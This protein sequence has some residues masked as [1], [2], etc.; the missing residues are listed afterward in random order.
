MKGEG[1][2][3]IE[4]VDI[5][6]SLT[7]KESA[8]VR[9]IYR[10]SSPWEQEEGEGVL[11]ALGIWNPQAKRGESILTP[12]GLDVRRHLLEGADNAEG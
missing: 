2:P 6:N 3:P 1:L 9:G 5:A 11:Y 7:G 10:W 12:L 8:A 4:A